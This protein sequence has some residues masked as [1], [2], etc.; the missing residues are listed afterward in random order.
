[1]KVF[2]RFLIAGLLV[3]VFCGSVFAANS[4]VRITETYN[5]RMQTF[6]KH[7]E[8]FSAYT[9]NNLQEEIFSGSTTTSGG[10]NTLSSGAV[11]VSNYRG[12]KEFSLTMVPTTAGSVTVKFYA[13]YGTDT[14]GNGTTSTGIAELFSYRT[15]LADAVGTS[16]VVRIVECPR[17]IAVSQTT[18]SGTT[19][20]SVGMSTFEDL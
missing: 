12:Y 1:M 10:T 15:V 11:D 5:D 7:V 19:T 8:F 17:I 3:G 18:T 9:E 13:V 14:V 4:N 16:A 20:L 6:S 2:K